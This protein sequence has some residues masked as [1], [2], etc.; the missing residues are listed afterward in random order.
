M[1]ADAHSPEWSLLPH[2][3]RAFFGLAD[4]FD[5]KD[6]KR[7]Y[8]GLI[9]QFK[10]EKFPQE[11]Q[12]IR[13]AYE[14]LDNHL[15]YGAA[16]ST[17]GTADRYTWQ[18]DEAAAKGARGRSD[19]G[20]GASPKPSTPGADKV[21]AGPAVL[22][23]KVRLRREPLPDLYRELAAKQH[24]LPYDFYAL[25][26]MSDIV[27]RKDGLQF[28]RWV[29][30]GLGEH[31]RDQALLGL[32]Y[33]Y[34]RGPVPIEAASGLLTA[35]SKVVR[36][37]AFF[38]LTESLWRRVL[39][40]R[41]FVEF[42]ATLRACETNLRDVAI[43]GRLAFTVEILKSAIWVADPQWIDGAFTLIEENFERIPPQVQYDLDVLD[44][45]KKYVAGRP[46]LATAQP[47]RRQID[48]ALRA[49]FSADDATRD[50][51]VL[52][53]AVQIAQDPERLLAAFPMDSDEDYSNFYVLWAIVTGDVGERYAPEAAPTDVKAWISRGRAL[54]ETVE[55]AVHASGLYRRWTFKKTGYLLG[56][57]LL[58]VAVAVVAVV[59]G[60][61]LS[62]IAAGMGPYWELGL[63][64]V[65]FAVG[66]AVTGAVHW[67]NIHPRWKAACQR[68]ER[69]L[70]SDVSRGELAA[71]LQRSRFTREELKELMFNADIR[72]LTMAQTTANHFQQD[73]GLAIYA[74]ALRF[75]I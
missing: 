42:A 19:A 10:P 27:Q 74:M 73:Y 71:F 48:D 46:A 45:L 25:A 39:R 67:R 17:S 50:R 4:A 38:A 24:K 65:V 14:L 70:Y 30:Q 3:P 54:Y 26:V 41:S 37:D 23:L 56:T 62:S 16:L 29:L 34:L 20:P 5:R 9:R 6:L 53:V 28:V 40:E 22:P 43:D 11:F 1:D 44:M 12:R 63:F 58:Y 68:Q 60:L 69:A 61:A 32:L 49:F 72:N 2:D 8:N 51:G 15:R 64:L 36:T 33:E 59:L 47:L 7:A 52:E 55:R 31:R 35:V 13:A 75:Q 66:V 18:T 21:D 57:S